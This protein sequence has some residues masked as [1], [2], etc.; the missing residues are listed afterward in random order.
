MNSNLV[1]RPHLRLPYNIFPLPIFFF[2]P[3]FSLTAHPKPTHS[4]SKFQLI[5]CRHPFQVIRYFV[6]LSDIESAKRQFIYLTLQTTFSCLA[7]GICGFAINLNFP[8]NYSLISF[9]NNFSNGM[10]TC[11]R[12]TQSEK[13]I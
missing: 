12:R 2:F 8:P 1:D 3:P 13:S 4:I 10:E 7:I 9:P 6:G 5:C 11:F